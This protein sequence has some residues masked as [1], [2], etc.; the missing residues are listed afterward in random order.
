MSRLT[1]PSEGRCRCG[2]VQF[3]I[4]APPILTMA[5]HCRGCQRM[6]ASAFSL[7]AA[8]PSGGLRRPARFAFGPVSSYLAWLLVPVAMAAVLIPHSSAGRSPWAFVLQIDPSFALSRMLAKSMPSSSGTVSSADYATSVLGAWAVGV[9]I[10][11]WYLAGVQRAFVRSLGSRGQHVR[12]A[13]LSSHG[14]PR[15]L[16]H[17]V[18]ASRNACSCDLLRLP[19]WVATGWPS[20]KIM[21]VGI[22][23]TL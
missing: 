6:S 9:V 19:T 4:S 5:C 7:S 16:R 8:I 1:L 2:E 3:R 15:I 13:P 21:S 18:C 17:Q 23:R 12:G 22:P 11:A 10:F 14:A 20:L